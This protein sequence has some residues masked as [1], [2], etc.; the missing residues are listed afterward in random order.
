MQ[1]GQ[2]TFKK[3]KLSLYYND[4]QLYVENLYNDYTT[5]I[6]AKPTSRLQKKYAAVP[7]DNSIPHDIALNY[8]KK[9]ME[10]LRDGEFNDHSMNL[11]DYTFISGRTGEG[12]CGCK[13]V[14]ANNTPY[15]AEAYLYGFDEK[16]LN[17]HIHLFKT[18]GNMQR[19]TPTEEEINEHLNKLY[20]YYYLVCLIAYKNYN[21]NEPTYEDIK[22]FHKDDNV[23]A[24]VNNYLLDFMA[25]HGLVPANS[26]LSKSWLS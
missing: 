7:G 3:P 11:V 24:K 9:L 26:T 13:L 4:G 21:Q 5:L 2:L 12:I 18:T 1:F 10:S 19:E 25:E 6:S 15:I 17:Q 20:S 14:D 8:S 23:I 22:P 16:I